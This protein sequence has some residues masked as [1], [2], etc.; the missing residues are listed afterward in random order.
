MLTKRIPTLLGLL[1]IGAAIF[2]YFYFFQGKSGQ[3]SEE[4]LPKKI[5]IT[6]IADNKFSVSW[7]TTTAT[8]GYIEYGEVGAKIEEVATD[9]RDSALPGD[10][11]LTHHI[12]VDSLQPN[13]SYA[14]RIVSGDKETKFDNN[15]SPYTALTGPVISTTPSSVNFYGTAI[16]PAN[17]PASGSIAYL[18]LPGGSTNSVLVS[19]T[20]N[21]T[22]TLSTMRSEDNKT[23]VEY[24]PSATIASVELESGSIQSKINV[25]LANS[26]PVPPITLGKNEDFLSVSTTPNIAEVAPVET[27]AP[28]VTP[29]TPSIFNVEP[30][31]NDVNAVSTVAVTLTN[32]KEEGE[33]IKTLRP[34]FRGTGPAGTTLSIALTGQKA[35][36]DITTV[37]TDK[38]WTWAPVIDLK[39][40]KQKISITYIASSGATQKIERG[41]TIST[42]TTGL[43]PAFVSSPSASVKA[44]PS[45]SAIPSTIASAKATS[46]PTPRAA[47]PATDS[48]IPVTGVIENTLL[49]AGL[50]IV[51]MV[52]GAALLAL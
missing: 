4:I 11:Y 31:G 42:S 13:T 8:E 47:M 18:T 40:G 14:F 37:S 25:T 26:E 20:G 19:E 2:G 50:G 28:I 30:I 3:V 15:G 10:K 17:Q 49:T 24:D 36:S 1:F 22:F 27:T 34:E 48:G 16:T 44:S 51:I 9:D 7:T 33:T 12:T 46:T 39:T 52:V 23:Y 21:Y 29:E 43:D 45:P 5:K 41:F 38:T 32:P 6:N 35:I